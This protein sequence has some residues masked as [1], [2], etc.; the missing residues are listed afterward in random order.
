MLT[1]MAGMQYE[2]KA[3]EITAPVSQPPVTQP[4]VTQSKMRLEALDLLRGLLMI[5]MA[6]DHTRDYFSNVTIDATAPLQSWPALFITRWITHL[7]A[8]GFVALAGASVY[9]QRRRGK[10]AEQVAWLLFTRGAWLLLLDLSLITFGWSFTLLAPYMNI[11]SAIGICMMGLAALQRLNVRWIGAIGGLIVLLHDLLDPIQASQLGPFGN[12]WILLHQQG[13]MLYHGQR[14]AMVYFP[15]LA[16]FGIMCL[17]YAFGAVVT[18]PCGARRRTS[19]GLAAFS[20]ISFTLL[21]VLHG[22][23]DT[24]RFQHLAASSR[25]AMSFFQVQKYPPSLQYVLVTFGVLL[26]LYALFDAVVQG[27]RLPR[28]RAFTEVFGRVP[29]FFYVLHIYLIHTAALLATM[30][31]HGDWRFWIGPGSTWGDGPPAGYGYGLP[32]V[33][34]IWVIVVLALYF[35][36]R[37][38]SHLKARRRDWWLSYL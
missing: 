33:Y 6:L 29:F 14:F 15:V 25:S 32:V 35:P 28:T 21:R 38:F 12:L 5:L 7:C 16:W 27:N 23:G 17:G 2:A 18:T 1:R 9:L 11:I 36:C 34:C 4:P 20:L 30:A 8:P 37:W 10:S 3:A 22:Y 24:Y 26:I 19:L 13:F 31:V